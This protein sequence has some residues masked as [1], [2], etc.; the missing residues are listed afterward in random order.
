MTTT[1]IE[2][3]FTVLGIILLATTSSFATD[4]IEW[5]TKLGGYIVCDSCPS[6]TPLRF[7]FA[8]PLSVRAG[9]EEEVANTS[10]NITT[11][12][13]ADETIYFKVGSAI[14]SEKDQERIKQMVV[15]G[16]KVL[17][18]KGFA[19]EE[20]PVHFNDNLSRKRAQNVASLLNRYG[21]Q[22]GD[23]FGVIE[24]GQK[25]YPLSRKVQISYRPFGR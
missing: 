19:S 17:F 21:R 4:T 3:L 1:K 23:V 8:V 14:I 24:W 12:L 15:L 10:Q 9:I 7:S 11:E 20:G 25:T 13:P 2:T 16:E 18:V 6:P 22:V 5:E